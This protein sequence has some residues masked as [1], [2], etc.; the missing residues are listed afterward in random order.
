LNIELS[1][2]PAVTC[3]ADV[4]RLVSGYCSAWNEPDPKRRLRRLKSIWHMNAT[5]DNAAVHVRGLREMDALIG[6]FC[7][8]RCGW[9]FVV[10]DVTAHG[11]HV[12]LTWKLVDPTGRE[13]LAGHDVGGRAA[14]RRFDRIV[15]FWRTGAAE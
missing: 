6:A 7:T 9:R 3:P 1:P 4:D 12:H 15:S 14:D 13:R 2:D 5:F 8:G 10:V 11:R